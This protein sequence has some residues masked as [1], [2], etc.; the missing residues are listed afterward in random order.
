MGCN[1]KVE[2]PGSLGVKVASIF[3]K[4]NTD[5][6]YCTVF[7]ALDSSVHGV[8]LRNGGKASKTNH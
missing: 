8:V 6:F 2:L 4:S 1:K 3:T 5:S 7:S